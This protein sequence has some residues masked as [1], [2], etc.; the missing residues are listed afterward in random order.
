MINRIATANTEQSSAV[1]KVNA[2]IEQIT[3]IG[4]EASFPVK[5][6]SGPAAN[7]S[8]WPRDYGT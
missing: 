1:G 2:S 4:Q 5:M 8:S 7:Y 3:A 6:P